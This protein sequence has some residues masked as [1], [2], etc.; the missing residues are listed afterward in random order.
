GPGT[1]STPPKM[2]TVVSIKVQCH[3]PP[4]TGSVQINGTVNVC[5]VVDAIGANPGEVMV[6]FS[7]ALSAMA[8]DSDGKPAAL[9]YAWV[10]TS[11]M[12][13][14]ATTPTPTLFCT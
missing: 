9:T 6:G 2:T 11:G 7:G 14:G 1:F 12:L 4:R 5:P 3:E 13:A 8:H 10:P